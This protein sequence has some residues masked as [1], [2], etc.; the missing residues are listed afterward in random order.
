MVP[1]AKITNTM[2][3]VVKDPLRRKKFIASSTHRHS[4]T[5]S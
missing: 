4:K 1:C 3:H 5:N 2:V